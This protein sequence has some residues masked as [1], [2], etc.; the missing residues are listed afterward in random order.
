[1]KRHLLV[2]CSL[3]MLFGATALLAGCSW[4]H[5]DR[6]DYYKGAP[7]T[8]PLE[9]PPDL[10]APSTS[11]S[12]VVPGATAA[13]QSAASTSASAASTSSAPPA[14]ASVTADANELHV[15]DSVDST[16]QRVGLALDR[17]QLGKV[18]GK[19][20]SARSY[21]FE[22]QGTIE[23]AAPAPEHHWYTRVLH[24][25][26]G[27]KPKTHSVTS[28][29]RVNVSDD[30][31]GARVSVSGNADDTSAQ[32]AAHRLLEALRERLS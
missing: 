9:V 29:L 3:P 26:G 27:D 28:A 16:W 12:L 23:A 17:S 2:R 5:H 8:R 10:D 4:F 1:M 30:N 19:D 20:E 14:A 15:A 21:T 13:T 25:F 24:P 7:E 31:G 22:F 32:A 11:K 6:V 18:T